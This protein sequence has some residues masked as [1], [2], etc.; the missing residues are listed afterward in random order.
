MGGNGDRGGA[1]R[2]TRVW[3]D[4]LTLQDH[5]RR[6]PEPLRAEALD[7]DKPYLLLSSGLRP[8]PAN[9]QFHANGLCR[10][11][12]DFYA[13]F[14]RALGWQDIAWAT[15]AAPDESLRLAVR[16]FGVRAANAGEL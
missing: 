9:G 1:P 4:R 3:T 16:P 6:R 2:E 14:R 12:P 8:S 13:A 15:D 7:L 10:L 5:R 11:Q